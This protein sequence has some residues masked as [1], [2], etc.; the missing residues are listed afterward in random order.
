MAGQVTFGVKGMSCKHCKMAV[1]KALKGADGV[2][3]AEVNLQA[4][5]VTVTYD[6]ATVGVDKLKEVVSEAGYQPE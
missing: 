6:S 2:T 4:A 5:N 1:E 3:D